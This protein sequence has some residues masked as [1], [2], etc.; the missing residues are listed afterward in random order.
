MYGFYWRF[1]QA[2]ATAPFGGT[3]ETGVTPALPGGA[4]R[5]RP[6]GRSLAYA[7]NASAHE[8]A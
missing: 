8:D 3:Y 2:S 5:L 4:V 1:V 7:G 6:R